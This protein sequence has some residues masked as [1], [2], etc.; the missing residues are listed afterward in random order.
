MFAGFCSVTYKSFDDGRAFGILRIPRSF[1]TGWAVAVYV[2][3]TPVSV[4]SRTEGCVLRLS[5]CRSD[6]FTET[7][8]PGLM[9]EEKRVM[10]STLT[11]LCLY[12]Q[13]LVQ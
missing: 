2:E 8:L 3:A 1:A 7:K 4:L 6:N 5:S 9:Y 12:H 10:N 11:V 13:S